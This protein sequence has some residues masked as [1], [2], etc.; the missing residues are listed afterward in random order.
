MRI[1]NLLFLIH[2]KIVSY[3]FDNYKDNINDDDDEDEDSLS[4]NFDENLNIKQLKNTN[5]SELIN[6]MNKYYIGIDGL[7]NILKIEK[8]NKINEK[9]KKKVTLKIKKNIS[10]YLLSK[11]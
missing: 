11:N 7:E 4:E 5:N 6:F 2:H 10:Q 8:L 9:R 1:I 3:Y